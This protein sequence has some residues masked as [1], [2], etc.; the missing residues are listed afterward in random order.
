MEIG[1]RMGINTGFVSAG[2]MGSTQ[3]MQYTVMGD[4]GISGAL[5][6]GLRSC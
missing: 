2:N 6:A 4:A 3:K 5:R 1:V